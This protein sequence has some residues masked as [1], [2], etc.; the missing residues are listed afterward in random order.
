M[1][2]QH[3]IAANSI[4]GVC[5]GTEPRPPKR[6]AL[7][8]TTQ[9]QRAGPEDLLSDDQKVSEWV[10]FKL[11]PK[12]NEDISRAFQEERMTHAKA[13]LRQFALLEELK[14]QSEVSGPR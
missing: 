9:P 6:S 3:S 5:P 13:E 10:T 1:G 14:H 11:S 4:V 2:C 12:E 7:N 8:F